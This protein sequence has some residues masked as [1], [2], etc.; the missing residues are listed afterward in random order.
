[1]ECYNC[2]CRLS[3]H[4]FCTS[5]RA[6]VALY[7]KILSLSNRFYND[8]LEKA[9][10]RDLTGAMISLKQSLQLNKNNIA[11]RNLLGLIYF[12]MGEV[13]SALSEWVLSKNLMPEKNIADGYIKM[14]QSNQSRLD[15][16]N[17]TIKKYNQ[18]LAYCCQGSQ[19]LAVIQLKKVLSMN[20]RFVQAHQL[21]ALLYIERKEWEHARKELGRCLRIDANNTTSLRYLK[22][23]NQ[24]LKADE[25]VSAVVKKKELADEAIT[26]RSGNEVIIQPGHVKESKGVSALLNIG[27]GIV[28]GLA[29]AWFLVLPAQIQSAQ[30]AIDRD[31]RTVSE[32]SDAK[33]VKITEL[34]QTIERL[35]AGTADL[36]EEIAHYKGKDGTM[37]YMDKLLAAAN[38]WLNTPEDI[39]T[40]AKYLEEL[41]LEQMGQ[42]VTDSF[43]NLYE[44]LT[45]LAGPQLSKVYYE[46]GYKA[47]VDDR[48]A[49]AVPGLE[50][51]WKYD[52]SNGD[53]LFYLANSYR[54]LNQLEKAK[55]CYIQ[56]T[57]LFPGTV[58]DS[59]ARTYLEEMPE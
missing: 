33:T 54:K 57:E 55:E 51:A 52:A 24:I 2:G 53:A 3:E 32:Q 4:D 36:E 41:D 21:L 6:D 8:G 34:E 58:K 45:V 39:T 26:Y 25:G 19:D 11:A 46:E 22:E 9:Q 44:T 29:V 30:A 38:T 7:K 15:S 59:R 40:V 37:Q 14:I 27:V 1:M 35:E 13:V 10:I 5:C 47:Y 23:V 28:V 20:P 50:K 16:M 12:E 48:Y 18:A 42:E 56:V 43:R 49:E 31:L 17:Q